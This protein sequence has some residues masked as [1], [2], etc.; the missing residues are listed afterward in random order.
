[1][2]QDREKYHQALTAQQHSR[3]L[4]KTTI[5]KVTLC[6]EFPD[7]IVVERQD[8]REFLFPRSAILK[9]GLATV[10]NPSR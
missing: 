3:K 6:P 8:G 10:A 1:M 9:F 4:A 5:A 7:I 2:G